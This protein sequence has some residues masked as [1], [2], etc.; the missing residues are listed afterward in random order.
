VPIPTHKGICV[1]PY[2][3]GDQVIIAWVPG[4]DPW[5]VGWIGNLDRLLLKA[6]DELVYLLLGNPIPVGDS[7]PKQ[8]LPDFLHQLRAGNDLKFPV[9]PKVKKTGGGSG[10]GQGASD[11][12]I[13]VDDD[14]QPRVAA[15]R[16][17]RPGVTGLCLSLAS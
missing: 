6:A 8:S 5:R 9:V 7:G 15:R 14:L 13:C 10:R 16:P 12:A 3:Q 1:I 2:R 4:D 11:D 17:P